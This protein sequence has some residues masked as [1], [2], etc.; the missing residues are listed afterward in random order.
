MNELQTSALR[1]LIEAQAFRVTVKSQST[2]TTLRPSI[3]PHGPRIV[4]LDELMSH[5]AERRRV[6][7]RFVKEIRRVSQQIEGIC[8]VP[9]G[10]TWLANMVADRLRQPL[11][12]P[13]WRSDPNLATVL[14]SVPHNA[15]VWLVDGDPDAD[16]D[17]RLI[18]AAQILRSTQLKGCQ[19][20]GAAVL[21]ERDGRMRTEFM[22]RFPNAVYY[23]LIRV[24]EALVE[25]ASGRH[26]DLVHPTDATH[27][28]RLFQKMSSPSIRTQRP[29]SNA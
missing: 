18:H 15:R 5:P 27:L 19:V 23:P 8:S 6:L 29:P 16:D 11:L 9:Y 22:K 1:A 13:S 25:L 12:I 3:G 7:N 20:M 14:G 4:D 2:T 28:L 21:F 26:A 10:C 24:E 17:L